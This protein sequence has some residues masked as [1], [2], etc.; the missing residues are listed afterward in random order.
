M[1]APQRSSDWK[2]AIGALAPGARVVIRDEEWMVRSAKAATYGG[3]SVHVVGTSELVRGKDAIFL[4]ELDHIQELRP[5]ETQLVH[6]PSPQYRRSRL[7]LDALLRRSPA[8]DTELRVGHRAAIE[9]ADYQL[10]PATRAL[11]QPRPR[12]LI[13]DGVGLGK[14]IEVGVLLSELIQRGRGRRILVVALKSIL[15]QFQKELWARFT[16]PLVRLD[17]VGIQRVQSRI[18]SNMNRSTTTTASSSPSTPSR[19]IRSTA[20]ISSNAT[21]MWLWLMSASTWRS[22]LGAVARRWRSVPGLRSS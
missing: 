5:E 21:G 15:S 18:P 13:A 4:S 12:M 6:D 7:Y 19:R 22:E 9:H 20:S 3:L 17:S 8:T 1:S 16:I 2:E 10:Q 11:R 14:T